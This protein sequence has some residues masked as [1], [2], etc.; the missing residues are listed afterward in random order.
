MKIFKL[1]DSEEIIQIGLSKYLNTDVSI[2][3]SISNL[4][5][6]DYSVDGRKKIFELYSY[7]MA[8]F[9]GAWHLVWSNNISLKKKIIEK[10]G[11]FDEEFKSWGL[12]DVELAYRLHKNGVKIV[13]NPL[14]ETYHQ[15]HERLHNVDLYNSWKRNLDYFIWEYKELPVMLQ[16]IF[17][18][19]FDSYKRVW[20]KE[21][22][23]NP[24]D[25]WLDCFIRFERA[26]R[27]L[28]PFYR[29]NTEKEELKIICV[30]NINQLRTISV[31]D[32]TGYLVVCSYENI[33]VIYEVQT[34]EKYS[35][36]MLFLF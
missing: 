27:Y 29:S 13:L 32:G 28:K 26:L 30:D 3:N 25:I 7:N 16:I 12:E 22:K 2:T 31:A 15:Y 5:T 20:R 33:E 36:I 19:Y 23:K 8:S 17:Y 18:D 11:G 14:I 1:A 6:V 21:N 24:C 10:Y 34:N 4:K 35:N 9:K